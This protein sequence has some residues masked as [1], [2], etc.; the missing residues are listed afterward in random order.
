VRRSLAVRSD[1]QDVVL[2]WKWPAGLWPLWK[3]I[4]ARPVRALRRPYSEVSA[5]SN[6]SR[7]RS[8]SDAPS[9]R[10]QR[11]AFE[12]S[13]HGGINVNVTGSL[14]IALIGRLYRSGTISKEFANQVFDDAQTN[15]A[16][17]QRVMAEQGADNWVVKLTLEHMERLR[18]SMG[19]VTEQ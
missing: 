1:C 12:I 18:M 14:V 15:I 19:L 17:A 5:R 9:D 16:A 7:S 6:F 4:R 10:T 3:Q 8:S 11:R 13:L 2:E